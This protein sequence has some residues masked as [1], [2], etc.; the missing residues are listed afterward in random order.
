MDIIV[1]KSITISNIVITISITVICIT[2]ISNSV[3]TMTVIKSMMI[4]MMM[5]ITRKGGEMTATVGKVE[6]GSV[7]PVGRLQ[8][9]EAGDD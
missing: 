3:I 6:R 1:T 5:M 9:L 2:V 7:E 4:M 8:Q